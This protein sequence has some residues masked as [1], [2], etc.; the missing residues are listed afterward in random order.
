MDMKSRDFRSYLK[1]YGAQILYFSAML[2]LLS[3]ALLTTSMIS[4]PHTLSIAFSFIG[5]VLILAK[6]S[7]YDRKNS[8]RFLVLLLLIVLSY[9]IHQR[10]NSIAPFYITLL[11]AGAYGISF[12]DIAKF[13]FYTAS[14]FLGIVF[15]GSL[16]G[17]V[18][19]LK[20]ITERGIRYSFGIV[21]PTDFAAHVFF[22]LASYAAAYEKKLNWFNGI[23]SIAVTVFVYIF[24]KARVDCGCIILLCI[25]IAVIRL[26][27][28]RKKQPDGKLYNKIKDLCRYICIWSMP[29]GAVIMLLLTIFYDPSN[30]FM[31]V[32]N[33]IMS[34]RLSLG[35]R[36]FEEYDVTLLGQYVPMHGNGGNVQPPEDYFFLDC[37]YIYMLLIYGLIFTL[38]IIG[39]YVIIGMRYRH[40]GVMLWILAVTALNCMIAHHLPDCA[41]CIFAAALAAEGGEPLSE[42]FH[43]VKV[44]AEPTRSST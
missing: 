38:L 35:K 20:Y 10:S 28:S 27:E 15:I 16:F 24:C 4:Y 34:G 6:L 3:D 13:Y 44:T 1:K 40:N 39:A 21:Y 32:L 8:V 5:F 29:A 14:V 33:N 25:G 37:S 22:I 26:A 17:Q 36:G 2:I 23:C 7:I 43:S 12:K 42:V 18:I 19:N 31:A 9:I 41:Y 11:T 30:K